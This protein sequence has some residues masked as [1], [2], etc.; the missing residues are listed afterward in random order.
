MSRELKNP[1]MASLI[2]TGLSN[3][4]SHVF[5]FQEATT[6]KSIFLTHA[7]VLFSFLSQCYLL[8]L[9]LQAAANHSLLSLSLL[10]QEVWAQRLW[11]RTRRRYLA[12]RP[13]RV[14]FFICF[15]PSPISHLTPSPP[16]PPLS[17]SRLNLSC[18]FERFLYSSLN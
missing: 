1:A 13:R 11:V 9:I 14:G 4:F 18:F 7:A 5:F 6:A 8:S 15:V 16:L 3:F 17:F 10:R 12:V 2:H